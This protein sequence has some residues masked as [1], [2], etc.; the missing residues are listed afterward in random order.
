MEHAPGATHEPVPVD[1]ENDIDAKSATLWVIG[2]AAVLFLSLW[3]LVPIFVQVQD[4]EQ[5]RKVNDA[6]TEELDKILATER[7]FL[8]GGN[9][10]NKNIDD[11]VD[12]LRR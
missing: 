3:V 2:G 1:P 6:P 10:K 9:P 4:Y 12:S 11:V 5:R 8:S 7:E